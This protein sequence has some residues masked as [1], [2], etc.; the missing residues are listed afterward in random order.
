MRERGLI[1]TNPIRYNKLKRIWDLK[2]EPSRLIECVCV[3]EASV[4]KDEV[5][6]E[7]I[8]FTCHRLVCFDYFR[9][10]SLEMVF[11][12][13]WEQFWVSICVL[14][15]IYIIIYSDQGQGNI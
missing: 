9:A 2:Y 13:N 10:F 14:G 4:H 12:C 11:C 1:K 3:F 8:D 5:Y 7:I 15:E 6:G